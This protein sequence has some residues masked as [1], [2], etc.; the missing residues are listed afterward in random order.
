MRRLLV[1][2]SLLS[3]FGLLVATFGCSKPAATTSTRST[4]SVAAPTTATTTATTRTVTPTSK[5]VVLKASVAY[6]AT[7]LR[8]KIIQAFADEVKQKTEGRVVIEFYFDSSLLAPTAEFSG[9]QSGVADMALLLSPY[10]ESQIREL[11]VFTMPFLYPVQRGAEIEKALRNQMDALFAKQ[12]VKYLFSWPVSY[13]F[14]LMRDKPIASVEDLKG[15]KLRV[16]GGGNTRAAQIWGASVVSIAG[17][18]EVYLALQQ[19]VVN[20]TIVSGASAM[21]LRYYEVARYGTVIDVVG[22]NIIPAMSNKAWNSLSEKDQRVIMEIGTRMASDSLATELQDEG[23]FEQ[24]LK[25]KGVSVITLTEEKRAGFREPVVTP[26][27]AEYAALGPT[28][29][30]ILKI[31]DGVLGK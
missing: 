16:S 9:L 6:G 4:T 25:A 28:A 2:I 11:G 19:G 8:G 20:G 27:R 18:G 22:G 10:V 1:A 26:L 3:V 13:R 29:Q 12:G 14:L 23:R 5:P 15:V 17:G 30:D 7:H 31:V 24:E 21:D